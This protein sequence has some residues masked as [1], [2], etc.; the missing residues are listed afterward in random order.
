[1]PDPRHNSRRLLDGP[2]RAPARAMM[3]GAGFTDEDLRKPQIGV[4]HCW[5]G[6]MPCNANHRDLAQ[7]VMAGIR[8]SGGTPV[9]INTIAINDAIPTGTEGMRASL[10]SREVIA[11]SVE[12]VARG[13]LLDGLVTISGCD[14]TIPA[15][16]M[17]LGRLNIPG[18]MLYGGSIMFGRCNRRTGEFGRRNLTIQDVFEAVGAYNAGH[19]DAEEF[20]DVEDHA[21]PGAGAC[22]GQFTANTMAGAYEMLG[23][24]PLNW[25]GIPAVDTHKA[26]AAEACGALVM[27][28]LNRDVRP[29]DIVTRQSFENA[30][31]GVM[32]TGGSTNA[33][34]HLLA[35]AKEYDVRLTIDDFDAISRKTPVIADLK[36]WGTYTAPEMF[37][38]G[39]MAVVGKRLK[40]AGLLH[41]A[42]MTVTGKTIGEAIDAIAEP[43]GQQV[44]RS[45]DQA[46]KPEGGI[47]ILRGNIAPGGCVI[48]LS[49]QK[50][51]N[52]TGPARVFEKGEDAFDAVKAGAIK[53]G[54]VVV[55]R[56]AGPKGAPG[57]P[58]MLHVTA[59]LQGAGLGASVVLITDGRFSGATHGFMIGHVVPEAA[60][61]GPIAALHDGDMISIDVAKRLLDVDLNADELRSRLAGWVSPTTDARRGVFAKYAKMVSSAS[62]GATTS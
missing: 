27:D 61:G 53:P 24:S 34:L 51:N 20:K 46:I 18:V 40:Q 13:H 2:D 48:K 5:I 8:A 37:E 17:V 6:T 14:K 4:A 16:T 33:V 22:G 9:E 15:M 30:I 38:A 12:L 11:D 54:D 59:A 3:K 57:M 50:R 49:G 58:E 19:I 21:C 10:I 39:G 55:I 25:N 52:H 23:M 43:D 60:E 42:A 29:R 36:P 32:A 56:N 28:L 1:M 62:E 31:C 41:G 35:T 47:A 26:D 44:I 7:K 45:L